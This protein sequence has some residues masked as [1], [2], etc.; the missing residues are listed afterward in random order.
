MIKPLIKSQEFLEAINKSELI[1]EYC[2]VPGWTD[3]VKVSPDSVH[4]KHNDGYKARIYSGNPIKNSVSSSLLTVL[5]KEGVFKHLEKKYGT[6]IWESFYLEDPVLTSR[7]LKFASV[8]INPNANPETNSVDGYVRRSVVSETFSTIRSGAGNTF[9]DNGALIDMRFTASTTNNQYTDLTRGI[10]VFNTATIG[11]SNHVSDANIG[12]TP[13]L[14]GTDVASFTLSLNLTS[15]TTASN[16]A[17]A[18]GDY[19][20]AGFGSTRLSSDVTQ[21]SFALDTK[22][23][24]TLNESGR[25]HINLASV[26][27]FG[28]RFTIDIDNSAPTWINSGDNRI[29]FYDAESASGKPELNITYFGN[30]IRNLSLLGAG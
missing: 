1:K 16:T 10:L 18:N 23:T 3:I 17:L 5:S 28:V 20:V 6:K 25:A 7:F 2:G 11:V 15:A 4:A 22:K 9:D 14:A 19:A 21:A 12:L 13:G 29:F 26:T 30:N 24:F 8:T 27:K